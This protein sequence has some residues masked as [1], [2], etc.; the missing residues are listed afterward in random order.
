MELW[1]VWA[2]S[3]GCPHWE[4]LSQVEVVLRQN[5]AGEGAPQSP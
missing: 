1:P 4:S 3:P 2:I 5:L